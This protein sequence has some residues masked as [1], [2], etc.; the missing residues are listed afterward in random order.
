MCE[1]VLQSDHRPVMC[2][3]VLKEEN[4]TTTQWFREDF[5]RPLHLC[6]SEFQMESDSLNITAIKVCCP[7]PC[8]DV[9]WDK[10]LV[11]TEI[12]LNL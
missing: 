7:I 9:L 6:M 5:G 4:N 2:E 12:L 11:S 10:R 1:D 3:F 8:E